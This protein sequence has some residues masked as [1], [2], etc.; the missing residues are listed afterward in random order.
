MLGREKEPQFHKP[1][2]HESEQPI[3][4]L[5]LSFSP[6]V[7]YPTNYV[8]YLMLC[9]SQVV[10]V[11]KNLPARAGDIKDVG[12]IPGLGRSPGGRHG[13]HSSILAWRIPWTKEPGG[14]R[15]IG[16]RESQTPLKQRT[17]SLSMHVLCF[18]EGYILVKEKEQ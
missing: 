2:V 13:S 4:S 12:S 5:S 7:Q 3:Y 1:C 15:P 18:Q 6:S 11:V 17:G 8:K 16:S 14:L 9:V 10:L